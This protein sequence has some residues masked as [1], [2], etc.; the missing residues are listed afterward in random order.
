MGHADEIIIK[1]GGEMMGELWVGG[2]DLVYEKKGVKD[3]CIKTL[4]TQ[5]DYRGAILWQISI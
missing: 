1:K 2:D 3:A 5:L 4:F